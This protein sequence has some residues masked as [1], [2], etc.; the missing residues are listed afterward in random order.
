[1]DVRSCAGPAT[2]T[3]ALGDVIVESTIHPILGPEFDSGVP[4]EFSCRQST[5]IDIGAMGKRLRTPDIVLTHSTPPMGAALA[6]Y[7]FRVPGGPLDKQDSR[8]AVWE[9]GIGAESMWEQIYSR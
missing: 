1:M 2:V 5:A 9:G 4:V 7:E 3:A 8:K 6:G